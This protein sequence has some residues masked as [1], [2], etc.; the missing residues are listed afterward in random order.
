MDWINLQ[1][2]VSNHC[3]NLWIWEFW[4]FSLSF[5]SFLFVNLNCLILMIYGKQKNSTKRD[6]NCWMK[7]YLL[8]RIL[9]TI[10]MCSSLQNHLFFL[11]LLQRYF[12]LSFFLIFFLFFKIW[13]FH[14]CFKTNLTVE[15]VK[16]SVRWKSAKNRRRIC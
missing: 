6:L 13:S 9:K 8:N 10:K 16:I 4:F 2:N 3:G 15:R 5:F 7:F 1:F 14:C 12:S 11:G